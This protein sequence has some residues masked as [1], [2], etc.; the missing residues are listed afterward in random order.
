MGIELEVLDPPELGLERT[1]EELR[2]QLKPSFDNRRIGESGVL[3]VSRELKGLEV[4][5]VGRVPIY[6]HFVS[7]ISTILE[8]LRQKGCEP[9]GACGMHNHLLAVNI[10]FDLPT[11]VLANIWNLT[12]WY[13]PA[14]RFL[15]SCGPSR[16]QLTR[17][18]AY[19][20]HTLFVS[21]DPVEREMADIKKLIDESDE[22][23]AHNNY[24]NIERISFA[25][26]EV[27][28]AFHY[29]YRF[30]DMD[31]SPISVVSKS[32]LFCAIAFRAVELS[33]YGVLALDAEAFSRRRQLLDLLSNDGGEQLMSD[34]TRLTEADVA[35]LQRQ[36][37]EMV[38]ELK[39]MFSFFDPRVYRVLAFLARTPISLLRSYGNSWTEID[40]VLGS[41]VGEDT[42]S[43]TT[44]RRLVQ[45]V[46]LYE[47]TGRPS[48]ENWIDAASHRLDVSAAYLRSLLRDFGH[49]RKLS[50]DEELG[51][52]LFF[53]R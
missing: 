9:S 16:G 29:E 43:S 49:T 53:Y 18:C 34:T 28:S 12:R 31:M 44:C 32:F 24:L 2:H 20:D 50:W 30:P 7:Q 36:A 1:L 21:L 51:S 23:R 10:G 41:M 13:A 38:R 8:I 35:E 25:G 19:C 52:Y 39:Q 14:L 6:D 47:L 48:E 11:I 17:R 26:P 40:H 46:E 42:A 37:T 5:V 22:V 4:K 27:V 33:K 3:T 15:T 45:I